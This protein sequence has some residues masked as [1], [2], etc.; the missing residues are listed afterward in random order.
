MKNFNSHIPTFEIKAFRVW[1]KKLKHKTDRISSYSGNY[2]YYPLL[3]KHKNCIAF[4]LKDSNK[5]HEAQAFLR[6]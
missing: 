3:D 5:T 6:S 4:I 2:L 1:I